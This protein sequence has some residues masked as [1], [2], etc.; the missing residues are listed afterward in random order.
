MIEWKCLLK[1]LDMDRNMN[2]LFPSLV[3]VEMDVF[4]VVIFLIYLGTTEFLNCWI[5][6]DSSCFCDS[7]LL[8]ITNTGLDQMY[9]H[10]L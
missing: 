2:N 7:Y 10:I 5:E 6:H 4:E 8:R 9:L 1:L 3:D